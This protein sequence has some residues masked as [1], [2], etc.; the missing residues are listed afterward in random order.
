MRLKKTTLNA[1]ACAIA[2][3]ALTAC[4][5]EPS[6]DSA[7]NGIN[8]KPNTLRNLVFNAEF[9]DYSEPTNGPQKMFVGASA[10]QSDTVKLSNG[11]R[12][13]VTLT[14][15]M[16]PQTPTKATRTLPN[17]TYTMEAYNGYT[18]EFQGKLTG[19]VVNGKFVSLDGREDI[20][21][22]HDY[23]HFL[24]YNSKLYR[25]DG[26]LMINRANADDAYVGYV[27]EIIKHEPKRQIVLF[28]MKRKGVRL[29]MK[30]T[31]SEAFGPMTATLSN[32]NREGLP[33]SLKYE[34]RRNN[35]STATKSA[36]AQPI[37]FASSGQKAGT[38]THFALSNE[39]TYL[40]YTTNAS[41][42]KIKFNSGIIYGEN[43]TGVE[44]QFSNLEFDVNGS[45]V[46]NVELT[47]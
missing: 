47:K 5:N 41:D 21:L 20:V 42:L 15:D 28:P 43:I 36:F 19:K 16:A 31:G 46:L 9:A 27:S 3:A 13:V 34:L 45:Y 40:L 11:L 6:A 18:H 39:Y 4:G 23:Y 30:I 2:C 17:D 33:A 14:P 25:Q 32:A 1:L 26:V 24:L 10:V 44:L 7:N 35:W 22:D 29:K 8:P 38:N 37:T 12:A